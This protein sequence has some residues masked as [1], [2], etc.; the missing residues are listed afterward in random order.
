[1]RSGTLN[2]P[3]IVGFGQACEI[4]MNEMRSDAEENRQAQRQTGVG[5]IRS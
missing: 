4:C 1:M 2:V 3:G 5:I